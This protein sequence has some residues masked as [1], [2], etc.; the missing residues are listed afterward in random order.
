MPAPRRLEVDIDQCDARRMILCERQSFARGMRR[1][2][3]SMTGFLDL[4]R[5]TVGDY[6][7]VFDHQYDHYATDS[8]NIAQPQ[9]EDVP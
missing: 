3:H 2:E 4:C 9:R 8:S 5:G 1:A 6:R 7:L